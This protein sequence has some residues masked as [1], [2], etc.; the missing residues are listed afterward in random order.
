[1]LRGKDD[2]SRVL[3]EV[4]H[5]LVDDAEDGSLTVLCGDNLREALLRE[6]A[7]NLSGVGDGSVHEGEKRAAVQIFRCELGRPI[8]DIGIP[9]NRVADPLRYVSAQMKDEVADGVFVIAGTGPDLAGGEAREAKLDCGGHLFE[10][11]NGM[12]EEEFSY[13][14]VPIISKMTDELERAGA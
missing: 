9:G 13:G 14:Q 1:L 6:T 12:I 3:L 7:K 11:A 2:L 4:S 10:F 5:H 8:A